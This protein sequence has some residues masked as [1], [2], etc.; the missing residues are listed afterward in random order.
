[1]ADEKKK[2]D[3]TIY[4]VHPVSAEDKAKYKADG[5]RII[6]AKFAPKGAKVVGVKEDKKE[7]VQPAA[8]SDS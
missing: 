8:Q 1:M 2:D 6:D 4:V 7:P 3:N 5:K